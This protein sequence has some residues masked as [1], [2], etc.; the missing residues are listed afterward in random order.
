[1]AQTRLHRSPPGEVRGFL[2]GSGVSDSVKQLGDACDTLNQRSR[3]STHPSPSFGLRVMP[4]FFAHDPRFV[5]VNCSLSKFRPTASCSLSMSTMLSVFEVGIPSSGQ[6]GSATQSFVWWKTIT[7][8][9][10]P[11]L[12]GKGPPT[13]PPNE[14]RE[15]LFASSTVP[16]I[17]EE[18]LNLRDI[19]PTKD[20]IGML[21]SCQFITSLSIGS[22]APHERKTAL[23][24]HMG[25]IQNGR[26][27]PRHKN[28]IDLSTLR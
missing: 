12:V 22:L 28:T 10:P 7:N 25:T 21:A 17:A 18:L 6:Y 3:S 1:M 4:I 15:S 13:V 16:P 5:V 24:S 2:R 9:Q 11:L 26:S 20:P 8:S 14:S 27:A 19:Q 23:S